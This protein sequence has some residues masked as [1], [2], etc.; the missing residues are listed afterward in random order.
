[1]DAMTVRL[2][3]TG[4]RLPNGIFG[5]LAPVLA[6][7]VIGLVIAALLPRL[8]AH[9]RPPVASSHAPVPSRVAEAWMAGVHGR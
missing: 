9:H 1:M 3:E 2:V 7:L 6:L 5:F 8:V 4:E